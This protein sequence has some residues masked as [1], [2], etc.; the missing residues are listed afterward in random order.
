MTINHL[1]FLF[2]ELVIRFLTPLV[3]KAY[4]YTAH[5]LPIEILKLK[6]GGFCSIYWLFRSLQDLLRFD[7]FLFVPNVLHYSSFFSN[8]L[9]NQRTKLSKCEF[10]F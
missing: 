1:M 5:L 6:R 4:L 9:T 2:P 10:I 7:Y 8:F 3:Y